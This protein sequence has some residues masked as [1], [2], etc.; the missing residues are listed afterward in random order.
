MASEILKFV[1]FTKDRYLE[2][3]TLIFLQIKINSLV[4][5]QGLLYG[6][7]YFCRGGNLLKFLNKSCRFI[8]DN[9]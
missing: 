4:T 1:G 7:K 3:E 5:Y 9:N 8:H 6:K 2:N